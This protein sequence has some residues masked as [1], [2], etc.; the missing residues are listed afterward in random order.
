MTIKSFTQLA[1]DSE[2]VGNVG[3]GGGGGED[4]GDGEV[5]GA[6]VVGNPEPQ[7][8]LY[9]HSTRRGPRT[10]TDINRSRDTNSR[11][12]MGKSIIS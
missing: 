10:S 1:G 3:I 6:Q 12:C 2:D 4:Q 7:Q 9:T 8:A 11:L 5:G